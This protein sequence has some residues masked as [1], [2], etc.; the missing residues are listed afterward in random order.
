[1]VAPAAKREAVA[2]LRAVMGLSERRDCCIVAIYRTTVRS[3]VDFRSGRFLDELA[4]ISG[5]IWDWGRL[6]GRKKSD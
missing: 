4:G 3:P 1:M 6:Y 5:A 2:H